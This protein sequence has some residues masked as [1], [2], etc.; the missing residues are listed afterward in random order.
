MRMHPLGWAPSGRLKLL[1]QTLLP[2]E[3]RWFEVGSVDGLIEAIRA[4]RVR[5]APAI[6]IAAAMDV[7]HGVIGLLQAQRLPYIQPERLAWPETAL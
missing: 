4:L 6:G 1:D 3:E 5:G 7:V 2:A